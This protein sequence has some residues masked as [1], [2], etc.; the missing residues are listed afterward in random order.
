[1]SNLCYPHTFAGPCHPAGPSAGAGARRGLSPLLSACCR[2]CRSSLRGGYSP[3]AAHA[4]SRRLGLSWPHEPRVLQIMYP[5]LFQK[6]LLSTAAP[7][8]SIIR[9]R[10][11]LYPSVYS[12][13][14]SAH[15]LAF[16]MASPS[17]DPFSFSSL[18]GDS[19][20][21]KGQAGANGKSSVV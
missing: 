1:M 18:L 2:W 3:A 14:A 19:Q 11:S 12:N 15:P 7:T 6:I 10:T 16:L 13:P 8:L 9:F 4:R 5:R 17:S 20:G 21:Q